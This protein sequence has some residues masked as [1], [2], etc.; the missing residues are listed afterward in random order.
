MMRRAILAL[1]CRRNPKT[2]NGE[3]GDLTMTF[4]AGWYEV[5]FDARTHQKRCR[6]FKNPS[7]YVAECL[8]EPNGAQLLIWS[9]PQGL[10]GVGRSAIWLSGFKPLPVAAPGDW[11]DNPPSGPY[12][13]DAA[14]PFNRSTRQ[15]SARE[16]SQRATLVN[17]SLCG[18][19]CIKEISV[20]IFFDGTNNNMVRDKPLNGHSNIVS[21]YDAHKKD[22]KDHFAYYIPGVGTPFPEIG[23]NGEDPSGKTYSSGGEARIHFAM[24]QV[25]NAVCRAS[26][27]VDLLNQA[28]MKAVVTSA[29]ADGLATWWRLSDS[30]MCA[31]FARLDARLLKAIE[32]RRPKIVRVNVAIFGFSRGAAEARVF[33]NW[34]QKAT[35][36]H[37][38]HA[39]LDIRFLGVMDTV[40][41]VFLADSSPVGSGL[42][43]W[44]DGNL[45]ISGVRQ[46][47]HFVAAHE[48][49]MSFPLS[50]ARAGQAYPPNT[51]ERVYP[52]AHSDV[53]GGYSPGDQGKS[54]AGRSALLSQIPLN[55][56]YFSALNAGV[57]LM[58]VSDMPA[59]IRRDFAIDPNVN[60][61]FDD[62]ARWTVFD[63]KA[64]IAV[65]G[66]H[67]S[68][69]LIDH[70]QLYWQWRA[71][72]STDVAFKSLKSYTAS[73]AQDRTD[74]WESELDWRVD[75][76]RARNSL[77]PK[78]VAA[79]RFGVTTVPGKPTP[80]QRQLLAAFDRSK[81]VPAGAARL[82]DQ[83]VHD[84][85]A[86]FWLLG[87]QTLA[88]RRTYIRLI[89][90]KKAKH[91]E[92]I[93]RANQT[94]NPG[95]RNNFINFARGYELNNFERRVLH[96][97]TKVSDSVP[98]MSDNE[99]SDMR[100]TAGRLTEG[101]LSVL[102]TNTRRE[103]HGHGRH[104]RVFDVS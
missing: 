21:L 97:D 92:Y 59:E 5:S 77:K 79:G 23:E 2:S 13:P 50:T 65:S 74:L 87:P 57:P 71:S 42:F 98:I 22:R 80:I 25:F 88:D 15:P 26:T 64:D 73:S 72:V 60:A 27:Q 6:Y 30:K 54:T 14:A 45:N 93:E 94:K 47:E 100:D 99:A 41:S 4:R 34:L 9:D 62:Y 33:A 28:E 89:K 66:P 39:S 8:L 12:Q 83:Y 84:S 48:I 1:A 10:H 102:G 104:R 20:G 44:V 16:L 24:L 7:V 53:G 90:E 46:T 49:R 29:G 18:V 32:G 69:R 103:P 35:Q 17:E 101:A 40:A 91:D 43:D 56:I 51:K 37:I 31:Y 82:F 96:A 38:G 61:A 85:H 19:D 3:Q 67:T 55:D 52:G 78:V 76:E 70:M 63:D 95:R 68:N 58:R 36:S 81:N 86:G 75:V 11:W